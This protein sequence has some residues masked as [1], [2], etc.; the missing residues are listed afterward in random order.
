MLKTTNNHFIIDER[1]NDMLSAPELRARFR[2]QI[3]PDW[4][5]LS[6]EDQ[7]LILQAYYLDELPDLDLPSNYS[8]E[9]IRDIAELKRVIWLITT[10]GT[11]YT[12]RCWAYQSGPED[13][14]PYLSIGPGNIVKLSEILYIMVQ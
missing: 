2:T 4:P 5:R 8:Y 1:S 11:R 6:P 3:K 7:D 12:G 9:D 10:D 13:Q 14:E